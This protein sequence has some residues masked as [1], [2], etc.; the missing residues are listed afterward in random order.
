MYHLTLMYPKCRLMQKFLNFP[1]S[2]KFRLYQKCQSYLMFDLLLRY[3][4]LPMF[5]LF[6]PFRSNLISSNSNLYMFHF[7]QMLSVLRP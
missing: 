3:R 5:R 2:L 1:N 7:R 4:L 6:L